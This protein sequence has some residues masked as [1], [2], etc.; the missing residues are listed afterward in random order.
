MRGAC[1]T[2]GAEGRRIQGKRE[3]L[4]K[5]GHLEHIS[6]DGRLILKWSSINKMRGR[7]LD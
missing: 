1:G 6:V 3:H 4:R 2:Y 7:G 5:I